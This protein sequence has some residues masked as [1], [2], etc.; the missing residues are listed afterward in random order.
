M[1]LVPRQTGSFVQVFEQPV[2]SPLNKPFGPVQLVG[3]G[4]V[5]LVPQSQPSFPSV[6]PF[7]HTGTVHGP[8]AGIPFAVFGQLAPL[9]IWHVDEQPSPLIVLPSS[10]CSFPVTTP[11]PHK[12]AHGLAGT[13]QIHP[14]SVMQVDEQPSPLVVLPSS[15]SSVPSST[16]LPQT[17]VR[18]HF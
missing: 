7:P 11:S 15:H 9:S 13:R 4:P 3:H 16:P 18:T 1:P 17:L 5:K 8:G 14:G 10:H 6:F 2:P 12:G